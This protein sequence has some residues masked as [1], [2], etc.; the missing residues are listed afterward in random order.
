ML[1]A[2]ETLQ[3]IAE[4]L[5]IK[6]SSEEV[7]AQ[8]TVE[9]QQEETV[10]TGEVEQAAEVVEESTQKKDE[11]EL[12]EEAEEKT[13]AVNEPEVQAEVEAQPQSDP[14]IAELEQQIASLKEILKGALEQENKKD[15]PEIPKEEPK[16]LTHSPEKPVQK[17]AAGIG[18]KGGDTMSRVFKYINNA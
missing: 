17:K 5:N 4:A 9:P 16:G 1:N 15:V 7:A 2:K 10:A 6:D 8:E 12:L 11:K 13:E 3:K 14:R 18:N